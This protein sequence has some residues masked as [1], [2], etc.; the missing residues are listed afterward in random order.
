M[1][2]EPVKHSSLPICLI[3]RHICSSVQL[4]SVGIGLPSL[5]LGLSY[6]FSIGR[7]PA[8]RTVRCEAAQCQGKQQ[9]LLGGVTGVV[10]EASSVGA[11]TLAR[12]P[13]QL[14]MVAP[15]RQRQHEI[16]GAADTINH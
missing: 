4:V 14:D 3:L 9:P 1:H 13:C 15:L 7:L 2:V 12:F 16:A 11:T 5:R 10:A 6:E 8:L